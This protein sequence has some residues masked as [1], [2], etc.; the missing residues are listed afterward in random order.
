MKVEYEEHI[1]KPISEIFSVL[2]HNIKSCRLCRLYLPHENSCLVGIE[3]E[4]LPEDE[5]TTNPSVN[6]DTIIVAHKPK[7]GICPKSKTYTEMI[8]A[9]TEFYKSNRIK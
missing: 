1:E 2:K 6:Y 9:E 7:N 4:I 3:L 5:Y 8:K